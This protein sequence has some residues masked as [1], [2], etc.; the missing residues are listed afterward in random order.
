MKNF[1]IK[2]LKCKFFSEFHPE[3]LH[4]TLT[5][6]PQLKGAEYTKFQITDNWISI[7]EDGL[8]N[9]TM[10]DAKAVIYDYQTSDYLMEE[11]IHQI[12]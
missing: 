3:F 5:Q 11:I 1:R 2:E 4:K 7:N 12:D 10:E 8:P 9:E 6:T